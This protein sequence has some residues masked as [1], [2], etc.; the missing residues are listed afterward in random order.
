MSRSTKTSKIK[1]N[2]IRHSKSD[3]IKHFVRDKASTLAVGVFSFLLGGLFLAN[4]AVTMA[5]APTLPPPDGNVDGRFGHLS[6]STLSFRYLIS[7]PEEDPPIHIDTGNFIFIPGLARTSG[8]EMIRP[9]NLRHELDTGTSSHKTLLSVPIIHAPDRIV[10]NGDARIDRHLNVGGN[11]NFTGDINV[12]GNA[13]FTGNLNSQNIGSF[14]RVRIDQTSNLDGSSTS[15]SAFCEPDT[16]LTGCSGRITSSR[17]EYLGSN[18][19]D[20]ECRVQARRK[21]GDTGTFTIRSTA[22]CFDPRGVN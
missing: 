5:N 18:P 3:Y 8:A 10:T 22:I 15:V 4:I 17:A 1:Y 14:Y 13:N 16:Y 7:M 19:I 21:T 11:A 12:S 6:T 9:L 20:R 2:S